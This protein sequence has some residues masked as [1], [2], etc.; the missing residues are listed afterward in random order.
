MGLAPDLSVRVP[1]EDLEALGHPV[2][3][4][5][6][7]AVAHVVQDLCPDI[8]VL[9]LS[10]VEQSVPEV[11]LVCLDSAWAHLLGGLQSD[12]L[13]LVPSEL[14]DLIDVLSVADLG[15]SGGDVFLCG[16]LWLLL[17]INLQPLVTFTHY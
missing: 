11:R 17:R 4:A 13:V 7:R 14:N 10:K 15:Q 6:R 3:V 1:V 9:V 2:L 16:S 5:R 8:L 12:H